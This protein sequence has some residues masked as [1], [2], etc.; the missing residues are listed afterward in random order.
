MCGLL[1]QHHQRI[2]GDLQP[3]QDFHALPHLRNVIMNSSDPFIREYFPRHR[4]SDDHS[5]LLYAGPLGQT[6]T[7][8]HKI[9][10]EAENVTP[11]G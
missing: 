2:T 11:R 5:F 6:D 7:M 3:Q 8:F 4:L 1:K 9:L 10:D